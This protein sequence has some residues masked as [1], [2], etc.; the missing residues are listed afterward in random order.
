VAVIEQTVSVVTLYGSQAALWPRWSQ[1]GWQRP[2]C[3]GRER[4]HT[5]LRDT[6]W[7]SA[8]RELIGTERFGSV[9]RAVAF[10]RE[11]YHS[12]CQHR[13]GALAAELLLFGVLSALP[14]LLT[15]TALLG[16]ASS[17]I[18]EGAAAEFR[19]WVMGQTAKVVGTGSPGLA[20]VEQLFA[21]SAKKAVTVGAVFALYAASRA[22]ISLIGSL[23]VVY[24]THAQRSWVGQ[25]VFGVVLTIIAM[26]VLPGVLVALYAG[27]RI[28]ESL[29]GDG[30]LQAV[31]GVG[32]GCAGYL[33]AV[34]W[35]AA[36]YRYVPKRRSSWAH[37]LPGALVCVGLI[38]AWTQLFRW[39]L[40]V[41]DANAVFGAI[42][43]AIS[44]MWWGYF[45][46]SSF[47]FG[48]ELNRWLEKRAVARTLP[49]L[50]EQS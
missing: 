8:E 5:S 27:R 24:D 37:Q 47:F 9:K 42:G 22:F 26:L 14:L 3:P 33:V 35:I 23:D 38:W 46:A 49:G 12:W 34:V 11:M 48:A 15:L 43:A 36:L 29:I 18:G 2:A 6:E 10:V 31:V 39:Y 7:R 50:K 17:L 28:S 13:G 19:D 41:F 20:V 45:C 16:S 21:T 30:V 40:V 25:R 4:L 44:L 32:F 1:N